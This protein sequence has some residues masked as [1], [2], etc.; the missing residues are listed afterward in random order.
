ME[1]SDTVEINAAPERVFD[2]LSQ[3]DQH[4]RQW[5][6]DHRDCYWLEGDHME[7][8]SVLYAEEILHNKLHKLRYRITRVEPGRSVEFKLLGSIGLLVPRGIFSI[9]PTASGCRFTATLYSPA[10]WLLQRLMPRQVSALVKHQQEE[11]E[12]L[13][14]ILGAGQTQN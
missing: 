10:G 8:G 13:Q 2:W 3:L 14:R 6:P 9:T 4:Y 7:E 12:S 11:G 1:I 5:H